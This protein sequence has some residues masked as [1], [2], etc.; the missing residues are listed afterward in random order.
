MQRT[1]EQSLA[2][3]T[4]ARNRLKWLP[5]VIFITSVLVTLIGIFALSAWAETSGFYHATQ[6]LMIFLGGAGAGS[7]LMFS[8]KT[9]RGK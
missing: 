9:K 3:K 2:I 6:H 1:V 7:S 8:I 5:T 4:E